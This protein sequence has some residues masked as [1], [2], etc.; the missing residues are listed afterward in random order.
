MVF[1]F[2]FFPAHAPGSTLKSAC[3][4]VVES[5]MEN[6]VVFT[7]CSSDIGIFLQ[8]FIMLLAAHIGC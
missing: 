3:A 1:L 4:G 8:V 2:V 7:L 5:S 6:T